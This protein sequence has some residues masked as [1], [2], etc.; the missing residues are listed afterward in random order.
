MKDV[1]VVVWTKDEMAINGLDHYTILTSPKPGHDNSI[2]S[3]LTIN[4]I[5]SADQ[6]NYI[7]VTA[8]II[9]NWSHLANR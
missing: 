5:T 9:Q 3:Q 4:S 2:V 7:L 1:T 8:I 6:G